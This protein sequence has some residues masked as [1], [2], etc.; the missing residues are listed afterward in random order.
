M[1][2]KI[3][4]CATNNKLIAGRWQFGRLVMHQVFQNNQQ[5]LDDFSRF[6]QNNSKIN[7]YLLADAIE[8]DYRLETMPH[9]SSGARREMVER[10]LNQLYRN[11]PYRTAHFINREKDKRKDDRFLFVALNNTDF[12][13][14]WISVIEAN[15][16]PLVGV[17]LLPMVS[18]TL[19][20]RMKLMAPHL[21]LSESLS[22]GLRQT[23]FYDGRIR[24]SRLAPYTAE[25]PTSSGY[26]YVVE[27][28]KT[29]LY[30]IS[31]RFITRDT[32]LSMV[33]PAHYENSEILCR[34][35]ELEQGIEATTIDLLRFAQG[36]KLEPVLL[37][38]NP[39][40]LHMHLLAIGYVPDNLAPD[41][42]SKAHHVQLASRIINAS[43]VVAVV[44]GVAL[45]GFYLKASFD[46]TVQAEQAA[47][48][49]R[50][51]EQLYDDVAK[52]FPATRIPGNDLKTAVELERAIA[53]NAKTPQRMMQV[54]SNAI[55]ASPE[56][57]INRLYWVMTN[58][59]NPKDDDRTGTLVVNAAE[60]ASL[61]P[62]FVVDPNFLYEVAFVNGEIRRF[63]GDYRAALEN[64]NRLA[65]RIQAESGVA[66]VVVLQ[67]PVN[68]SSYSNLQGST[69]DERT[70][71]QPAALFKLRV[72]L[73]HEGAVP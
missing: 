72:T 54:L 52:N 22:S 10:K 28:E 61:A 24:I 58:E 59:P 27:S 25:T 44:A 2:S 23:Y 70:A 63:N 34:D 41:S 40:L 31:K 11:T 37:R 69:T 6:L 65:E 12:L 33:I 46:N 5:G 43:T 71:Q 68:V 60:N 1:F 48:A 20:R 21:I 39:E 9:A 4:L 16:A 19:V 7:I 47:I 73:K 66:Q 50:Q 3:I 57:E 45:S 53:A 26:F 67:G 32:A 8:E 55:E 42:L 56:I 35:V 49:T 17:Y 30:L 18:Q 64:V 36:L 15:Q 51:Q 14:V 62:G 13:Q 38:E 29:R